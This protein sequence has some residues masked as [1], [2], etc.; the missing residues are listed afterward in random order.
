[1]YSGPPQIIS[2]NWSSTCSLAW[3]ANGLPSIVSDA[4]TIDVRKRALHER[5]HGAFIGS[6]WVFPPKGENWPGGDGLRRWHGLRAAK[7][8]LESLSEQ[9]PRPLNGSMFL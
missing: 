7:E 2:Q 8:G 3:L 1:M 4:A 6:S 9:I 5:E